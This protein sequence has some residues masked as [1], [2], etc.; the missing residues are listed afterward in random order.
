MQKALIY[1]AG[2]GGTQIYREL[3]AREEPYEIVAFVDRLR[4]GMDR[5]LALDAGAV[6]TVV[7]HCCRMKAEI[8]SRDERETGERARLNFGH[9]FGHAI[10]KLSGYGVWLHGEAVAA[11]MVMA[12]ELSRELGRIGA[13]DV[14]LVSALVE[15]AG[16]PPRIALPDADAA[17]AAMK[18]DKKAL[19]GDIRFVLLDAVGRTSVASVPEAAV[20]AVMARSG[21]G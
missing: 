11:G 20:R 2:G 4:L 9:T 18:G 6:G 5:L 12:A 8:V 7:E 3:V 10:E 17:Y 19:A 21:W 1:G 13:E 16:L 15:S 14:R